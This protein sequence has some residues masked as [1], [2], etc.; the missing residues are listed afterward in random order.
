[1]QQTMVELPEVIAAKY[2]ALQKKLHHVLDKPSIALGKKWN[3]SKLVEKD[4]HGFL[5]KIGV[6]K[7]NK[8][9]SIK[10]NIHFHQ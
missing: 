5:E 7:N 2:K 8:S 9:Y 10:Y 6:V 3:S 1:M 4:W